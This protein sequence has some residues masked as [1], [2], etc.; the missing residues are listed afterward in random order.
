MSG[1]TTAVGELCGSRRWIG[2]AGSVPLA[3][4][5]DGSKFIIGYPS[6]RLLKRR[7]P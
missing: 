5:L 1:L 2:T 4:K 6:T 3:A 7:M